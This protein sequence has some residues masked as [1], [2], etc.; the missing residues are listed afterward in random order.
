MKKPLPVT[1]ISVLAVVNGGVTCLLGLL[2]LLGSRV[3]FTPA[4][5]GP[6]RIAIAQVFGP[7]SG[8]AGWI[9]LGLGT[10]DR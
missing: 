6:N 7:F 1:V 8:Q 4:G 10:L 3:L 5:Y 9:V 2:T